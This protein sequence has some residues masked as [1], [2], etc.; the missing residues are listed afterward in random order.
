MRLFWPISKQTPSSIRLKPCSKR[1]ASLPKAYL[2]TKLAE[3]LSAADGGVLRT[4]GDAIG[5]MTALPKQRERGAAWQQAC[6]LIIV[7]ADAVARSSSNIS[8]N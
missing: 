5:Y 1:L 8:A 6:R 4:I 2:T 7:P 3:P